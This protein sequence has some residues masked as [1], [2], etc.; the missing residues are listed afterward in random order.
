MASLATKIAI[1]IAQSSGF[2]ETLAIGI[3]TGII[4]FLILTFGEIVPKSL[5]A[6]HAGVL[7]LYC[8]YPLKIFAIVLTPI[9][10]IFEL[11]IKLFTGTHTIPRMTD[12]EMES[13]IDLGKNNG[14]LDDGEHER[15][16]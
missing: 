10:Y 4:T 7:A 3:S 2:Q 8:A 15:I 5:G 13:F 6:K 12:E 14:A 1:D 11:I 16:K 9:V